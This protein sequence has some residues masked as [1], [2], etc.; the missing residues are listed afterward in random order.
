MIFFHSCDDTDIFESR[1]FLGVHRNIR[2]K[3]KF[4]YCMPKH[5]H[6]KSH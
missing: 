6:E 2:P 1:P 4:F 5:K 3:E